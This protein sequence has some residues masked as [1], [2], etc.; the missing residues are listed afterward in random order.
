MSTTAAPDSG[1]GGQNGGSGGGG[2]KPNPFT[3]YYAQLLHQQN[4][5]QDSVRTGTGCGGGLVIE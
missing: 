4:M 1:A 5:L 2:E 3:R